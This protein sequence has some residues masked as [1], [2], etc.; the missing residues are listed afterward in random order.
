MGP[1]RVA[2]LLSEHPV[3]ARV[4][5][6]AQD[7][8]HHRQGVEIGDPPGRPGMADPDLGLDRARSM[9]DPEP[10]MRRGGGGV[11]GTRQRPGGAGAAPSR[12]TVSVTPADE[13]WYGEEGA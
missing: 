9:D 5:E 11:D 4:E 2:L 7:R 1:V 10:P 8:A 3:Q 6:P 12:S 13:R